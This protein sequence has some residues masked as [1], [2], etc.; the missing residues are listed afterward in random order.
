M[1]EII[2]TIEQAVLF[3]R[4]QA[5]IKKADGLFEMSKECN[6][7][8]DSLESVLC[9]L[10]ALQFSEIKK[11]LQRCAERLEDIEK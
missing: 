4:F 8:A 10:D 3:L 5:D 9:K 11:A 6:R 2:E 7:K 1:K